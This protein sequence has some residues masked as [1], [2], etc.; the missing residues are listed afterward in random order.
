LH[1]VD[2]AFGQR[3]GKP[4]VLTNG[5]S[6]GATTQKTAAICYAGAARSMDDHVVRTTLYKHLIQ[7]LEA[8]GG[9]DTFFHVHVGKELSERGQESVPP[10]RAGTMYEALSNASLFRFQYQENPFTCGQ[11]A[12]GKFWKVSRCAEMVMNYSRKHGITYDLFFLMRPDWAPSKLSINKILRLKKR[13]DKTKRVRPDQAAPHWIKVDDQGSNCDCVAAD[14]APG[15]IAAST[16]DK[17][18]CCDVVKREPREC[19]VG[20]LEQPEAN[21]ILRRHFMKENVQNPWRFALGWLVRTKRME[22]LIENASQQN[23]GNWARLLH[24]KYR[25]DV[26]R[27]EHPR[28][29]PVVSWAEG[30]DKTSRIAL[31]HQLLS[32]G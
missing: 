1:I 27:H 7:P 5:S 21:Y 11:Q 32:R 29:S 28:M 8:A 10:E 18:V 31:V 17:A 30:A 19:F 13:R 16:A 14:Y 23:S 20:G 12:T 24:G 22:R 4:T 2:A 26:R 6:E 15:I 25:T 3:E 9:V